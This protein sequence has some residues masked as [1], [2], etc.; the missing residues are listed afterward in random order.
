MIMSVYPS[1][2]L[3]ATYSGPIVLPGLFST[4]TGCPQRS[5]SSLPIRRPEMSSGPPGGNGTTSLTGLE[6]KSCAAALQASAS[7]HRRAAVVRLMIPPRLETIR[8]PPPGESAPHR[9]II[10]RSHER[11]NGHWIRSGRGERRAPLHP[12][13]RRETG[14]RDLRPGEHSPPPVGRD[15]GA[16]ADDPRRPAARG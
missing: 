11:N 2:A 5:C 16:G 13:H 6:G 8:A 9:A 12:R 10:A 7:T 14:E 3:F 1:G 4:M 15:R